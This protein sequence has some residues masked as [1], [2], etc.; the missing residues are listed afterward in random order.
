MDDRRQYRPGNH[1]HNPLPPEYRPPCP[2]RGSA[3]RSLNSG[4]YTKVPS[5][6]GKLRSRSSYHRRNLPEQECHPGCR[7]GPRQK[8]HSNCSIGTRHRSKDAKPQRHTSRRHPN[9]PES[10]CHPRCRM[11][12]S[13]SRERSMYQIPVDGRKSAKSA[14]P[15]PS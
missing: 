13:R 4:E 5:T 9:P 7:T 15:S 14:F 11:V 1:H 6:A 3:R 8:N 10:G 2:M 12:S